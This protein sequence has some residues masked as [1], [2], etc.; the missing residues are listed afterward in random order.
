MG[1]T[2][3]YNTRALYFTDKLKERM[4]SIKDF[5]CTVVEA[6][7]GYGKTTAVRE[8]LREYN[9]KVLWQ[10]V[11]TGDLDFWFGFCNTI[12]EI[13]NNIAKGLEKIGLPLD[14][15][16]KLEALK[17]ISKL[18]LK[19]HIFFVIDDYHFVSSPEMDEFLEFLIKNMPEKF[20]VIIITRL[21]F[22]SNSQ[23]LRL[24]GYINHVGSE[25]LEF[26]P[27]DITNY[28]KTCGV[29]ITEEQQNLLYMQSEG[30]I[31]ALYLFMLEYIDQGSFD[32]R[33]DIQELVLQTVYD[34]LSDELKAFLNCIS[35]FDNFDLNQAMYMWKGENAESLLNKLLSTN[36]FI[37]KEKSNGEYHFHNIFTICIR[38]EFLK[39]KESEKTEI[40]RKAGKWHFRSGK[41]LSAMNSFYEAKDFENLMLV[42]EQ[43]KGNSF[44]GNN[45]IKLMN[46]IN[47]CP[48]NIRDI[49]HFA[50]LVYARKLFG[51]NQIKLFQN[52]CEELVKNIKNDKILTAED[53]DNL[54]G[55]YELLMSFTKYNS[56]KH[57]SEHHQRARSLIKTTSRILDVNSNWSFGSPS[58]LYMF[59]RESGKLTEEVEIM[60]SAMPYYYSVSGGHGKGAEHV[61]EAEAFFFR[62]DMDNAEASA[63]KA[64]YESGITKQWSI[65]ICAVFIQCRVLIYKGDY[66][67]A[68]NLMEKTRRELLEKKLYIFLHTLEL[69]ETYLYTILGQTEK[70]A[71]WVAEGDISNTKLLFP[72]ISALQMFYGRVLLRQ[73]EYLK[74][75][76]LSEVF[77]KTASIFPNLLSQI[78]I[79]IHLS[80]CHE[81]LSNRPEAVRCLDMALKIANADNLYM[82]FVENG[83][84][85]CDLLNDVAIKEEYRKFIAVCKKLYGVYSK[86]LTMIKRTFF[87]EKPDI[88]TGREQEVALL[89]TKG[90]SNKEIGQMLFISENTVKARLK[91]IFEKLSIQSRVQLKEYL[92]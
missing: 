29:A 53:R 16:L 39:L 59:H 48:G 85:I 23:E 82:P 22:L 52:I 9:D 91:S 12:S 30:W 3:K 27:S 14:R 54:L 68:S 89:A 74:L 72:A 25:V 57:M 35:V 45:M 7:M 60:K 65:L 50:M 28:Y 92:T 33:I 80:V 44:S 1:K 47:E 56:I 18:D 83:E 11:Y 61:M 40:W 41:Y 19:S 79:Y 49:H 73:K 31:S 76:G 51:A 71:V 42:L 21:A 87:A 62:G 77:L 58:I 6:P 63:H 17:L 75:I 84:Y 20:H 24:K 69:C 67:A 26:S 8:I 36:A 70:I 43:D 46:F 90:L 2:K 78:Y 34:P 37:T 5:P 4:I 86:S 66:S 88:L 32:T 10:C 15:V 64:I 55:E 13:D 81:Q 38:V